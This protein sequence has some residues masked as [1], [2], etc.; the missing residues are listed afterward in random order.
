MPWPDGDSDHHHAVPEQPRGRPTMRDVAAAAAVSIK[1]VSR[2][3]HDYPFIS[4]D[5]RERVQAEI[6]RVDFQPNT[7]AASLRRRDRSVGGIGVLV[8]DL[9]DPFYAA[10]L[11]GVESVSGA[12]G[13]SLLVA[14]S[15]EDPVRERGLIGAFVTRR[16]DGLIV[17]SADAQHDYLR[18]D[19]DAGTRMVFADRP[20]CGLPVDCVLGAH[21]Q[22][23][24]AAVEHLLARGHRAVAYVGHDSSIYTARQ[25]LDGYR[26]ALSDA[27]IVVD[28]RLVRTDAGDADRAYA[29]TAGLMAAVGAPT[30]VFV[31]N[32]RIAGGVARA[33]ADSAAP[34]T[35]L[36]V[37]DDSEL[38]RTLGISVVRQDPQEL[39]RRAAELLF[40]RLDGDAD[41]PRR[42]V[43]P[44]TLITRG[45]GEGAGVA[46][47]PGR[48]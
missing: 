13:F 4:D 27:G 40:A 33:L 14:S 41:A 26:S 42:V 25:R 6:R 11:T 47:R 24:R 10:M 44:V 2:V 17:T 16:L 18:K 35:G 1:T 28:E 30:A 34:L 36:V 7:N 19:L 3:V 46:L 31:D 39:G 37:F 22:G 48:S 43:Q 12:L 29:V 38:V 8:A 15:G 20:P 21:A 5:V 9:A 32:P 45:S 23:A